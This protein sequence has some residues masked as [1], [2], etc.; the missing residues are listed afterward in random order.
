VIFSDIKFLRNKTKEMF[1][2]VY[3]KTTY[4]IYI[5]FIVTYADYKLLLVEV[6]GVVSLLSVVTASIGL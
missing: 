5:Q 3:L 4:T 6:E 1:H 2:F